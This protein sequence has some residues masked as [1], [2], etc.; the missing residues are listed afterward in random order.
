MTEH[1]RN[2]KATDTIDRETAVQQHPPTQPTVVKTEEDSQ[3]AEGHPADP[4]AEALKQ[5]AENRDRW[6]RAVA[7]LENYRKRTIAEKSNYLKYR[8]EDLLRDLLPVVD[9]FERALT[10]AQESGQSD[11]MTKGVGMI[12]NMLR[13]LLAKHGLKE[14]EALDKPFDPH[15]HEAIAKVQE[16]GKPNNTVINVLEKGYLYNERLLR[17]SKV[18][19]SMAE[20]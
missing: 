9:N 11:P 4:L 16:P 3:T 13:D 10:H 15:F 19:V 17:P 1:D 18:V 20:E 7:D 6:V 12:L 14:I 8:N 5:A 2:S